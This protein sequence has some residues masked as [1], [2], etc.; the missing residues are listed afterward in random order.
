V[1][2]LGN[3]PP[4]ARRRTVQSA[5]QYLLINQEQL[6]GVAR[7]D[8]NALQAWRSL[9]MEGRNEFDLRYR[10]EYLTTER[11]HR[12]DEALVRMLELL[13]LPGIGKIL[14]TTLYVVRTP[15]RLLK[16]LFK[17]ATSRPETPAASERLVLDQAMN[18]WIDN[19][20]K[21]AVRRANAHPV[22]A[23]I[24]A[25]F[26]G[27]LGEQVRDRYDQGFRGFQL[28][29]ADEVDRTARS[30]YEDLQKNPFA[31]NVLRGT[32]FTLEVASITGA[33]IAGGLNPWDFLLVPLAASI[34][35]QLVELLGKQY[36][37]NQRESA[38]NR[39]MA[40]MSQSV[41]APIAAWLADW[42]TTGGSAFER[43]QLAL[44]RIPEGLRE[45]NAMVDK[46]ASGVEASKS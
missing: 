9:V 18:G 7:N 45:L 42:P 35:H 40:M 30:L 36:V 31:L 43:L 34:T 38:R 21:E 5:M 8:L 25:G 16:N 23:H 26:N 27:G 2:V 32:K 37:D 4:V 12:F 14:S 29:M 15:Y 10:R 39:Q 17:K 46:T 6:L 1:A 20:R 11:F 44:R 33:V 13:E 3:P 41:S 19:L 24:N 22:W 28:G